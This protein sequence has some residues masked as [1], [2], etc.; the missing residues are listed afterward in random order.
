MNVSVKLFAALKQFAGKDCL[1]VEV[2]E[3]ALIGDLRTK[4]IQ[5]FPELAETF[6]HSMFAV[7]TDYVDDKVQISPDTEIACIPPVS[8]G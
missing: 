2:R 5:Q 7:D 8:G 1:D 6:S 4:M 3:G